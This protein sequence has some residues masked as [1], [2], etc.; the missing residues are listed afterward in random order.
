MAIASLVLGAAFSGFGLIGW[1]LIGL[2]AGFLAGKIMRGTGYGL[3]GD[4]VVGLVGALIGGWL[5]NL[6]VPDANLGL[7]MSIIV[8]IIGACILIAIVRFIAGGTRR[9]V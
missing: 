7:I 9:T 6:L 5:T 3:L 8:S 2:I 1:L 4:I